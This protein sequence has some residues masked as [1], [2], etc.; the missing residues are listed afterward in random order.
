M[1]GSLES[2][3]FPHPRL[4]FSHL[5]FFVMFILVD[6]KLLISW[7]GGSRLTSWL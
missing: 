2:F 6:V 4:R 5:H 7:Q 3:H 1:Y